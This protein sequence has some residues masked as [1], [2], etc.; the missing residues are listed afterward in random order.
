MLSKGCD[1]WMSIKGRDPWLTLA[2]VAA[3]HGE[4]GRLVGLQAGPLHPGAVHLHVLRVAALPDHHLMNEW[5]TARS[6]W[7]PTTHLWISESN[8]HDNEAQQHLWMSE[9]KLNHSIYEWLNQSSFVWG[10]T[11]HLWISESKQH[12]NE[13]QQHLWMSESQLSHNE[14]QQHLW[15]SESQLSHNEAQQHLWMGES[16]LNHNTYE[17]VNQS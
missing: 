14:A 8:H 15:I 4:V 9:S 6:Q 17:W 2:G 3:V 11:T 12:K 13:A 1:P 5:I 16:K 10:Q 7:G